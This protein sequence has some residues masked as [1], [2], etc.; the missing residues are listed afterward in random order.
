ML[1]RPRVH[2]TQYNLGCHMHSHSRSKKIS[3][4]A[5]Q[6]RR[7]PPDIRER[8]AVGVSWHMWSHGS[9]PSRV[10]RTYSRSHLCPKY[11]DPVRGSL[12]RRCAH[13]HSII[14][15]HYLHAVDGGKRCLHRLRIDVLAIKGNDGHLDRL[16]ERYLEYSGQR[17]QPAL[18]RL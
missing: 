16:E 10:E 4:V 1:A 14:P 6:N 7:T 9:A 17:A 12:P 2:T 18:H 15:F 13:M 3:H 5:K 8:H 11:Q